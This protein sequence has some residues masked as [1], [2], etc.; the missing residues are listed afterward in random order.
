[1]LN[2]IENLIPLSISFIISFL[3]YMLIDRNC[4]FTS[5]INSMLK[6]NNR[7]KAGML[8]TINLFFVFLVG[9][10]QIFYKNIVSR[11]AFGIIVGVST[12]TIVCVASRLQNVMFINESNDK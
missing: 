4:F 12:G 6:F 2:I 8:F 5:K 1:M 11:D 10:F 7:Y 3:L 9:V